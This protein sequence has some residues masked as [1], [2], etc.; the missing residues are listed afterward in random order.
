MPSPGHEYILRIPIVAIVP[1]NTGRRVA[2]S[3]PGGSTLHLGPPHGDARYVN[4]I[5]DGRP[6]EVFEVDFVD[7]AESVAIHEG[8]STASA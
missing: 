8:W 4:V 7:R 3:I 1:D 5:W 6:A 2:R